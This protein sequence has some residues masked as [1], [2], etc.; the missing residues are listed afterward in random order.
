MQTYTHT[1][2]YTHTPTECR[3]LFH[4]CHCQFFSPRSNVARSVGPGFSPY[5]YDPPPQNLI[6]VCFCK[7]GVMWRQCASWPISHKYTCPTFS[8]ALVYVFFQQMDFNSSVMF[9]HGVQS[10]SVQLLKWKQ[11]RA[12]IPVRCTLLDDFPLHWQDSSQCMTRVDKHV[13][14]VLKTKNYALSS[15]CDSEHCFCN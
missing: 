2:R 7:E 14:D 12:C 6:S 10:S 8:L 15:S 3:K 5:Q 13:H 9:T 11:K 4:A 1:H